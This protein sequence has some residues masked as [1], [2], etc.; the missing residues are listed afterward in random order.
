MTI[1]KFED[2]YFAWLEVYKIGADLTYGTIKT[3]KSL[4]NI[5]ILPTLKN[6][7][8]EELTPLEIN[9]CI[10]KIKKL[11]MKEYA[12]QYLKQLTRQCFLDGYIKQDLTPSIVKYKHKRKEGQAL[13]IDQREIFLHNC[14]YLKHGKALM[15]AYY[16]GVR[17]SELLRLSNKDIFENNIHIRGTKT[18]SSDRY[19]PR[20]KK[21][22]QFLPLENEKGFNLSETT[23]K[24]EIYKLRELCGFHIKFKDLRT[25]FGTICAEAGIEEQTIAKWMGHT[26]TQTTRKYYIKL[27]SQFEQS[28]IEI[29]NKKC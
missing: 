20:F 9:K 25:T 14:Q 22:E 5:H 10:G 18:Q 24:R 1:K 23:L 15:F 8:L 16:T 21:L 17:R 12:S 13:T 27:L 11:R 19:V 26:N 28:Q 6:I 3:I 2:Y 4:F 29:F 7:P